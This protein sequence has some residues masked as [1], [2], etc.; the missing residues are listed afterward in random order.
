MM[1][2]AFL[3][4]VVLRL[5]VWRECTSTANNEKPTNDIRYVLGIRCTYYDWERENE[6]S[7]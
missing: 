2:D 1:F 6:Y 3:V 7:E 4:F 5:W